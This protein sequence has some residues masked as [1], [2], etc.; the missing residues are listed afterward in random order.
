MAKGTR[1]AEVRRSSGVVFVDATVYTRGRRKFGGVA[2][3]SFAE[4]NTLTF[5]E[6]QGGECVALPSRSR[7]YSTSVFTRD[8][9]VYELDLASTYP[10]AT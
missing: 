9:R 4:T 8:P 7:K 2:T 1:G 3:Y 5:S 10:T 6:I